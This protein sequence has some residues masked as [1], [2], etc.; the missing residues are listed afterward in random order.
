MELITDINQLDPHGTYSYADYMQ[1][2]L[3]ETVELF[4]G[5][6]MR[7]SPALLRE[8][9]RVSRRITSLLDS[10]LFK[11]K[12]EVYSAPFD[13]R[14]PK[15]STTSDEAIYTV[16]QPD[17]CII[18]DPSKLD[19][20]G[21]IGA[22]DTVIE[23]LSQGN[24]DRDIKQKFRLYEEHGVKEYWIVAPG[25]QTIAVYQLSEEGKYEL[26]QEYDNAGDIPVASLPGFSI[27]WEHI[28][29]DQI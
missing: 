24:L 19:R 27:P 16:V 15:K 23:I 26:S 22:P 5:K 2:R 17:I 18:C 11:K 1:W 12:C 9:Q 14:L 21:C 25:I 4:R 7:M 8:H 28:F 13:V 20:R 6:I 3:D 10:F 29:E